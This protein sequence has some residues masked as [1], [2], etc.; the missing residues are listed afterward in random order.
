MP[1]VLYPSAKRLTGP[2]VR[3][4]TAVKRVARVSTRLIQPGKRL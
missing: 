3:A 2:T 1:P 4:W